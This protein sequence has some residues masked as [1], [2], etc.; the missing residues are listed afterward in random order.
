MFC[1][2]FEKNKAQKPSGFAG[3]GN[4]LKIFEYPEKALIL[5]TI[6]VY[7]IVTFIY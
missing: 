1:F 6:S 7:K 3:F 5:I 4:F 2:F